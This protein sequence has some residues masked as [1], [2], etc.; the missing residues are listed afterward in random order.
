ME[1]VNDKALRDPVALAHRLLGAGEVHE[2][3]LAHTE[4]LDYD[5]PEFAEEQE[6]SFDEMFDL[7]GEVADQLE[8]TFAG[9]VF[10][11]RDLPTWASFGETVVHWDLDDWRLYL[12]V[13]HGDKEMPYFLHLGVI[14][15]PPPSGWLAGV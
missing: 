4:F 11:H 9:A 6:E 12:I 8:G 3:L 1:V 2:E 10:V 15:N 7:F 14:G 5:T 13:T